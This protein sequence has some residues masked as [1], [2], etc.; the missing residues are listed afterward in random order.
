MD[1]LIGW[2]EIDSLAVKIQLTIRCE[3]PTQEKGSERHLDA[4]TISLFPET[5]SRLHHVVGI[6]EEVYLTSRNKHVRLKACDMGVK[7]S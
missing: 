3:P 5:S 6:F 1:R 7:R 2:T 4:Y